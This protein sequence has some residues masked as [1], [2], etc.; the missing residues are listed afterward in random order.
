MSDSDGM[1]WRPSGKVFLN[2]AFLASL[3]MAFLLSAFGLLFDLM[4]LNLMAIL[5]SA[6]TLVVSAIF[7][8]I[9]LD[10]WQNWNRHRHDEWRL[11]RAALGYRNLDESMEFSEVPLCDVKAVK[12][13]F[14]RGVRIRMA[15][16]RAFQMSYLPNDKSVQQKNHAPGDC[17]SRRSNIM[18]EDP[19]DPRMSGKIATYALLG[20]FAFTGLMI[21][22]GS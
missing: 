14:W 19:K 4:S 5:I 22:L 2:R 21:W 10:E 16:G 8:M 13:G 15:N 17:Q 18:S 7:Y 12:R 11:T 6:I 9:V 3:I 1:I 20:I